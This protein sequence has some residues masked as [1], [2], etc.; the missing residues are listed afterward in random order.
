MP[1][2]PS[3][4]PETSYD[5][6]G[7][8]SARDAL[9]R[10]DWEAARRELG[11][12]AFTGVLEAE[13]LDLFGESHWWLGEMD[14]CIASREAAYALYLDAGA[15]ARA[16]Q[17]GI[18]L[19]EHHMF[20]ASPSLASAWLRRARRCLERSPRSVE[21]GNLI[22]REAEVAHGAGQ[23]D[24]AMANATEA[25]E[26]A[27]ELRSHDLEAESLQTLGRVLIDLGRMR[28]GMSHLDEA[29]LLAIE[30][31]LGPYATGKVYC[32]LVG[33]CED[34]A[35]LRRAAEWTDASLRWSSH[36]PFAVF[37]GLCRVKRAD[38][39]RWRG[40]WDEAERE[41]RKACAELESLKV[42]SAGAAWAEIGE[43]RRRV[44]DLNGAEE[45][46]ERARQMSAWP[47][48][49]LALLRLAQNRAA[50]ADVI[51]RDALATESWNRL[52]RARLL[53]AAVEIW[54]ATDARADA[55]CAADELAQIATDYDTMALHAT[56]L[57]ANARVQLAAGEHVGAAASC[58]RAIALW[59]ELEVPYETATTQLLLSAA[60]AANG[61]VSNAEAT[62]AKA[63]ATL[64]RLGVSYATPPAEVERV[65]TRAPCG[66][67]RREVEVLR[68][69]ARGLA[70]K[71]IAA[72]LG[73]SQ[74]TVERHLSNIFMKAGVA[75][76]TAA[77]AFAYRHGLADGEP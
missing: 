17:V 33:A 10:C 23:L 36:H 7:L 61:D 70:N 19:F 71:Q 1:R 59:S 52:A 34:V 2:T 65:A 15:H 43:I 69:A 26:L 67:T 9:R 77:A 28:D 21:W 3:Q 42:G 24:L 51:I 63:L 75:S 22:L 12:S 11:Q 49:G 31:R 14:V 32:S 8:A 30:G 37:P 39:L 62:R 16:G 29:M 18:W 35:D 73:L 50:D 45:A 53:P 27:L 4:T 6:D 5:T 48:A 25:R 38:V 76:R 72:Q 56:S 40:D 66:L 74:K 13:R 46:F 64:T 58:R 20:K 55:R 68:L 60:C 47:V 54:L 41:A 57:V 44:G